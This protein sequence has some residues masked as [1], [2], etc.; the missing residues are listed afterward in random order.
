MCRGAKNI[1]PDAMALTRT[2][3]R[4]VAK[5]LRPTAGAAAL[6]AAVVAVV[7]LVVWAA[8]RWR[9]EGIAPFKTC[10]KG[11]Y[12]DPKRDKC[13]NRYDSGGKKMNCKGKIVDGVCKRTKKTGSVL[14]NI[15]R[16]QEAAKKTCKKGRYYDYNKGECVS[17]KTCKSGK[18]V[19]G[20]CVA[21]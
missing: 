5:A 14:T 20:H 4:R 21:V 18:F 2:A 3:L 1:C 13:M 10:G 19:M 8:R 11:K 7:L 6:A 9:R 12:Y 16:A 15:E 17:N